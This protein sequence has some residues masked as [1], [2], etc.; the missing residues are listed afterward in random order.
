[1][2]V[3]DIQNEVSAARMLDPAAITTTGAAGQYIDLQGYQG[4]VKIVANIGAVTGTTPTLDLK[5]QDC[6]TS[7]GTYA[8]LSTPVAFA[9]KAAAQANSV[10]SI[11]VDTRACR[12]FIKLYATAGGTTPSFTIGAV[13]LGQKQT[14]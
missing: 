6:D 2:K 9:Q 8:D 5:V 3:I 4:K 12:R 10:D 1:M 14:I 13:C 11:V 7:G